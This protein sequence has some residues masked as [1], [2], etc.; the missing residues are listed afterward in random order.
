MSLEFHNWIYLVKLPPAWHQPPQTASEKSRLDE[1][2][3]AVAEA[4][5]E[6]P[7]KQQEALRLYYFAGYS[8]EQIADAH[9]C[10]LTQI[11]SLHRQALRR[12]R[13]RLSGFVHSRYGIETSKAGCVLCDSPDRS[14]IDELILAKRPEEPYSALFRKLKSRFGI[15]LISPKTV[16]GHIKYHSKS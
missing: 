11:K 16:I 7:Q 14:K 13:G 2:K 6:L 8:L 9:G 12:L 5:T 15:R 1:L 10:K 3:E 4:I